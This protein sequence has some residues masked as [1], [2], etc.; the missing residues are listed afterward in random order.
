MLEISFPLLCPA[1][2]GFEALFWED[3]SVRD[4][5]ILRRALPHD[6]SL[7]C[8][9]PSRDNEPTSNRSDLSQRE[10]TTGRHRKV[11]GGG[12]GAPKRTRKRVNSKTYT[13]RSTKAPP[14]RWR[15]TSVGSGVAESIDSSAEHAA[16]GIHPYVCIYSGFESWGPE[17]VPVHR[18]RLQSRPCGPEDCSSTGLRVGMTVMA[19]VDLSALSQWVQGKVRPGPCARVGW[20]LGSLPWCAHAQSLL[21]G[22]LLVP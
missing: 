11:Q 22:G 6:V 18:L 20:C 4:V 21:L 10:T 13:S 1:L 17:A 7:S 8:H 14:P 2:T 12:S 15:L 9:Q 3:G 16:S 5:K 19:F